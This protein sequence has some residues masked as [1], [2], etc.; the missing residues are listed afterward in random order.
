LNHKTWLD[1]A[2]VLFKREIKNRLAYKMT[3]TFGVISGLSALI[4]YGFLGNSAVMSVTSQSYGMGLASYLVSGV[5]FSSIITT[6]PGMFIQH[7]SA[8]Q[9]EEI[10]VTPTGFKAYLVTSS[11][12]DILAGLGGAA[13][14]FMLSI[15]LLGLSF[16]FNVPLLLT[17]LALGVVSSI[18]LGFIGL[19]L[20]L[21]YKQT[22]IVS[23]ILFTVTGIVGNMIVPI[24]VLPGFAQTIAVLTPQYYFFTGIRVALGSNV[25]SAATIL[26]TFAPYTLVLLCLGFISLNHGLRFLRHNGTHR[27]V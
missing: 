25:A 10:L 7:S 1:Q 13:I 26:V 14:F 5:A 12:F 17:I 11:L 8:N 22:A 16:S 3:L 24:Q 27:W 9:L 20:Q 15:L 21:V 23:W 18:G 4:T 2:L 19:G 6:G